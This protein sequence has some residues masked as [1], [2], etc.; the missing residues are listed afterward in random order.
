MRPL[1][2]SSTKTNAPS[3]IN[4]CG[5][6][7]VSVYFGFM[8]V[9]FL[10]RFYFDSDF[11]FF[12]VLVLFSFSVGCA[13][14]RL[15]PFGWVSFYS[16]LDS[17]PA[18]TPVCFSAGFGLVWFPSFLFC[19]DFVLVLVIVFINKIGFGFGFGCLS[20]CFVWVAF[21]YGLSLFGSVWFGVG[22]GVVSFFLR[23]LFLFRFGV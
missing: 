5:C 17:P 15:G 12:L 20:F 3:A 16:S 6:C 1:N 11:G 7:G 9:L 13:P 18:L 22:F 10:F 19:S 21:G 14:L 8:V 23:L 2:I 4:S